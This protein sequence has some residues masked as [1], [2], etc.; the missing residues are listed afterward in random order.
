MCFKYVRSIPGTPEVCKF[1]RLQMSYNALD[2]ALFSSKDFCFHVS[3][4]MESEVGPMESVGDAVGARSAICD[5]SP[6]PPIS[7]L[8]CFRNSDV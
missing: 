7:L 3:D 5:A 6:S 2:E 8:C 1:T 4:P